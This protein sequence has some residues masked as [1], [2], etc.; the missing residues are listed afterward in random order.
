MNANVGKLDRVL[1]AVIGAVLVLLYLNSVVAGALG[2]AFL[3]IGGALILTA[4]IRFCPIYQILGLN[5][6][7]K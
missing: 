2:I 1:R 6:C 7:P 5:S 3:I 4:L